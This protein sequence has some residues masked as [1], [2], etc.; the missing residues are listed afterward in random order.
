MNELVYICNMDMKER[1]QVILEQYGLSISEF[2]E[3]LGVQKSS[4]SHLVSGRNMP[5]FAFCQKLIQ[6]FPEINIKWFISGD[7]DMG[8]LEVK[9][10]KEDLS[11][12]LFGALDI[13]DNRA[14]K[15]AKRQRVERIIVFYD[16]NTFKEYSPR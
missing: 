16:D 11:L 1:I 6:A 14:P 4:I 13:V 2:S 10:E 15:N 5:S 8:G 7:G 9:N 12:D 3:Q